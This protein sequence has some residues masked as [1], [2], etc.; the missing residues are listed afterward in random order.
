M[1]A[2]MFQNETKHFGQ[3]FLVCSFWVGDIK[4]EWCRTAHQSVNVIPFN[5]STQLTV[6]K[7]NIYH[8]TL[9]QTNRNA[10][11]LL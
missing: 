1:K 7:F 6:V 3:T 8:K 5:A 2:D 11:V 10:L 4:G 9:H